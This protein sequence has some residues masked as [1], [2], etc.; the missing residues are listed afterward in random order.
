MR[1]Q[2]LRSEMLLKLSVMMWSDTSA[3]GNNGLTLVDVS[4]SLSTFDKSIFK[5]NA[6]SLVTDSFKWPRGLPIDCARDVVGED[7]CCGEGF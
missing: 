4:N 7:L 5:F 3:Y 2:A 1:Y 6:P